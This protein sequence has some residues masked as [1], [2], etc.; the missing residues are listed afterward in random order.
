MMFAYFMPVN[1]VVVHRA[2]LEWLVSPIRYIEAGDLRSRLAALA[3]G[4]ANQIALCYH[5]SHMARRN[6][7]EYLLKDQV[8]LKKY[9]YVLRPLLAIRYIE[10]HGQPPPIEFQ[11]LVD[12]VAPES[13]GLGIDSLLKV[14]PNATGRPLKGRAVQI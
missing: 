11:K 10:A 9:C 2:L 8:R 1:R 13:I 4:S 5:Y 7:R 3:P 12:A 6:A 14:K